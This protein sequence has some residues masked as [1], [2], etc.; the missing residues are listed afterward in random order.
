MVKDVVNSECR[1]IGRWSCF[2][3]VDAL[4]NLPSAEKKL[5][6]DREENADSREGTH[7]PQHVVNLIP[8]DDKHVVRNNQAAKSRELPYPSSAGVV[9]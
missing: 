2:Q 9:L 1:M 6:E 8:Q 3:V 4:K 7:K 5:V